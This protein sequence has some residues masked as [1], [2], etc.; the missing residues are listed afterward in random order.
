MVRALIADPDLDGTVHFLFQPAEEPGKGAQAMIDDGYFDR[1]PTDVAFGIHNMPGWPAGHLLT[2]SGPLM[3]SEDNFIIT[4]T[5]RGGHASRPQMV[6]DPITIAAE[7]VTALQTIVSRNMDPFA[8]AVVTVGFV[9]GGE[10]VVGQLA[11]R[12]AVTNPKNTVFSIKRFMGRR[13]DDAE[14]T[15]TKHPSPRVFISGTQAIVRL[16][17]MQKELDRRAGL[18]T[19]G[20]ITGYRGSPLGSVDCESCGSFVLASPSKALPTR[21]VTPSAMVSV[22]RMAFGIGWPLKY[23]W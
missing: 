20:F 13:Y 5:G 8:N 7:V 17:L 23:H 14:V 19:A 22:S 21:S 12:Q 18:N 10:R 4:I 3:A 11:K 9:K 16:L 6:I 1:F 2:R 15:K